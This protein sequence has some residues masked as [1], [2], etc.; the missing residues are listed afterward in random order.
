MMP[1][2][3]HIANECYG[4]LDK[5]HQI[6]WPNY[7][8]KQIQDNS[9]N[10]VIQINGRKRGLINAK[11]DVDEETLMK[12]VYQDQNIAKHLAEKELKRKIYIKNKLMNIII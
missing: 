8:E 2:L 1:I 3:P 10:I 11:N 7:D 6:V 9:K 12:L 5:N 4:L